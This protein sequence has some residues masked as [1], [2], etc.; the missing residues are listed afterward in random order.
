MRG[1]S[2][3]N[4]CSD[5]PQ[6]ILRSRSNDEMVGADDSAKKVKVLRSC[7]TMS[8]DRGMAANYEDEDEDDEGDFDSEDG[9]MGPDS[10]DKDTFNINLGSERED[11]HK[12]FDTAM[13]ISRRRSW[14]EGSAGF[15][16]RGA[17][18]GAGVGRAE[19]LNQ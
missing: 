4:S 11:L 13:K 7:S 15:G 19:N 18:I 9:D 14:A 16:S 10:H 6:P 3:W 2:A 1:L 5:S 8:L 17:G 12:R